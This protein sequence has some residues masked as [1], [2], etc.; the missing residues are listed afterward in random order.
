V[1]DA[2]GLRI[3]VIHDPGVETGRH[4]RLRGW[5]PDCDVIVY[6]HTHAPELARLENT[7]VLNPG[8]PTERRRALAHTM[9]VIRDGEPSLVEV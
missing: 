6:G 7:W 2:N 4:E 3:G 9:I 5:F 8:S 1:A